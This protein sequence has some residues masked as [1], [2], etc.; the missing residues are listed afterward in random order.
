MY[1]SPQSFERSS[2][3]G[4]SLH[5]LRE[6]RV[7]LRR[8]LTRRQLFAAGCDCSKPLFPVCRA[9][10]C[11]LLFFLEPTSE[12]PRLSGPVNRNATIAA[13]QR[14]SQKAWTSRL[15][16][17]NSPTSSFDFQVH[18]PARS[19]PLST[20]DLQSTGV[21]FHF[22]ANAHHLAN[23]SCGNLLPPA[24]LLALILI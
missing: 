2:T 17:A 4:V 22:Q 1:S 23:V 7:E 13:D 9:R 12:R 11:G 20:R 10:P 8:P 16:R 24:E 18:V 6:H 14:A 5:H 15:Y 3:N 19:L 21:A